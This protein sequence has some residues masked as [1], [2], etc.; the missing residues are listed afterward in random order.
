MRESYHPDRRAKAVSLPSRSRTAEAWPRPP[1][2]RLFGGDRLRGGSPGGVGHAGRPPF[3]T[4][5]LHVL[6]AALFTCSLFLQSDAALASSFFGNISTSMR[7]AS[8]NA[9]STAQADEL[10]ALKLNNRSAG[11]SRRIW[12]RGM[13]PSPA[14]LRIAATSGAALAAVSALATV[15][16]DTT[17]PRIA[18]S[19]GSRDAPKGIVPTKE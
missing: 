8:E 13:R 6:V 18:T 9:L 12:L 3:G 10:S 15:F 17:R 4:A 1:R 11:A 19:P 14:I 16:C 2:S 5:L 7:H